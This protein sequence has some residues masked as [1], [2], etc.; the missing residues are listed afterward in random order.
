MNNNQKADGIMLKTAKSH[1]DNLSKRK[2]KFGFQIF[3]L[4]DAGKVVAEDSERIRKVMIRIVELNVLEQLSQGKQIYRTTENILKLK[5]CNTGLLFETWIKCLN[6]AKP[7]RKVMKLMCS[8]FVSLISSLSAEYAECLIV[9]IPELVEHYKEEAFAV[10]PSVADALSKLASHEQRLKYLDVLRKYFT[11]VSPNAVKGLSQISVF[12]FSPTNSDLFEEFKTNC[13]PKLLKHGS[14]VDRFIKS[15]GS[16]IDSVPEEFQRRYLHLCLIAA[17]QSFGSASFVATNLPKRLKELDITLR[18]QYVDSCVRIIDNVGICS[19]GFCFGPLYK[20]FS[21][22]SPDEIR[23]LV[24]QICEIATKYGS[25]AAW[26]FTERTT[27]TSKAF[28]RGDNTK[29]KG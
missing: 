25:H 3:E 20:R 14:Y 4:L 10:V 2:V 18:G 5:Q 7:D 22:H 11:V 1:V 26:E 16:A 21:S 15:C 12:L 9:T 24:E 8:D 13:S 28:W 23:K 27:Q 6:A 17:S 29:I 19:I